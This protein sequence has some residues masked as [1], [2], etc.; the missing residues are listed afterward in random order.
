[1]S[2]S[3]ERTHDGSLVLS[4][5]G[6][7]QFHSADER[8]YHEGLVLPALAVASKRIQRDL[9]VLIIG[10]GDG[11]CAREVFKSGNIAQVDLVDYDSEILAMARLEL[12]TLNNASLFDE[13]IRIFNQDAWDFTAKAIENEEVYDLIISDLT[14]PENIDGARFHSVEWYSRLT[15]LLSYAGVLA[16][17]SV[18]P[19][20]TPLAYWSV[21]N[22]LA[23][24]GL[25]TRAYHVNIPSFCERGYGQDWGFFIAA[26]CPIDES[27]LITAELVQ[28]TYALTDMQSVRDLFMLPAELFMLQPQALPALDGSDVLLQYFNKGRT[29]EF[30]G[31]KRS[32]FAFDTSNLKIPNADTGKTVL[33]LEVSE[34]LAKLLALREPAGEQPTTAADPDAVLEDILE[35]IPSLQTSQN[36]ELV[37]D[38]LKEPGAFLQG[39][40]LQALIASV[41]KR[42]SSLP[43]NFA[44]ELN[45]LT[46]K[47]SDWTG[48][49]MSL[50]QLGRNVVTLLTLVIVVGNLLYPDMVY[51]KGDHG[52]HAGA[53]RHA[54]GKHDG[55][56]G[57]RGRGGRGGYGWNGG[58]VDYVGPNEIIEK[59]PEK[60]ILT[61]P[62]N[63]PGGPEIRNY[64]GGK[65]KGGGKANRAP[66]VNLDKLSQATHNMFIAELDE[67]TSYRN[68]LDEELN[69]YIAIA[70]EDLAHGVSFGMR[71]VSREEAI[72]L[73][74]GLI[75]KSDNKIA[76]LND[77]IAQLA[78]TST[79]GA[80]TADTTTGATATTELSN[81]IDEKSSDSSSSIS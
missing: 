21:F 14:V 35:M 17:N 39:V 11:L 3:L 27:E 78:A 18:S 30:R 38:F 34:A 32:S 36:P 40:D 60:V 24:V 23:K 59:R 9:R 26:K 42:A 29:I 65:G 7:L 33:P 15:S 25:H 47:L 61:Q 20:A 70:H 55:H 75:A 52:D 10:G 77:C 79:A 49:H 16:V 50:M 31:V 66:S 13:R 53:G 37:A 57:N 81:S 54:G 64:G 67:A 56:H 1:M 2:G 41:S 63:G 74:Q 28:P 43:P 73:T 44:Q 58:G 51:A 6:D 80:T 5:N 48:D 12:K 19:D 8:I 46:A 71:T 69:Q 76:A 72:R 68:L 45:S 4:I 22:G 62:K